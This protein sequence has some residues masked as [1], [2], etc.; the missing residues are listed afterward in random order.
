M[1][2]KKFKQDMELEEFLDKYQVELPILKETTKEILDKEFSTDEVKEVLTQAAGKS[3][4]GPS[5]QSVGIFKYI[6]SEIP[7]TM[8]VALNELTFVPGFMDSPCFAWIKKR[9]ITYIPKVVKIPDRID[10]LRPLSLLETFCKIKTRILA[11]RLIRPLEEVLS[12]EQHGFRP[13]R[14]T[15]SC[16]L[17]FMEAIQE[18]ERTSK[19]IQLLAVDI[20]AA[21][22]TISPDL[23]KQ[24]MKKVTTISRNLPIC[25]TQ[26]N[27]YR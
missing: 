14:S 12:D 7:L 24:V 27:K 21:F 11:N 26:F 16:S 8:T 20:K 18:V 4:L 19:P 22:D 3:A 9:Y 1:V 13:G 15:Q 5:G 6:F 17:P 25:N 10:N 23:V 2:D